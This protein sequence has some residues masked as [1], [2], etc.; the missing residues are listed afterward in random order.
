MPKVGSTHGRSPVVEQHGTTA[1]IE[2]PSPS[3]SQGPLGSCV[4]AGSMP[5]QYQRVVSPHR[6]VHRRFGG[7]GSVRGGN[8][9]SIGHGGADVQGSGSVLSSLPLHA[10]TIANAI[11]GAA[12]S[13][14][15]IA[16]S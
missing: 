8:F 9:V 1:T 14:V 6:G 13:H 12:A 11:A 10:T 16:R 3:K 15:L 2:Q 5:P 4:I 7:F